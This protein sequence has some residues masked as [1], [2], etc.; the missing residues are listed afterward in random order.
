MIVFRRAKESDLEAI[1]QLAKQSGI[2]TLPDYRHFLA[3]R[4]ITSNDSFNN[5][6]STPGSEYYLF[7]LEDVSKNQVVGTSAIEACTGQAHPFYSFQIKQVHQTCEALK[8]R[9]D[10]ALLISSRMNEGKSE[11]CTLFLDPNFRH[12]GNGLLLSRARFLFMAEH[13]ERFTSSVI[14]ELRGFVDDTG[15]SPFWTHVG[16]HFFHIPFTKADKLTMT[17][18][19]QFID[20]LL[21]KSPI[22]I[23]LLPAEAQRVIGKPNHH[24]SPAMKI[25][26]SQGF[27]FNQSVDIFDAGPT[28]E[29]Q[30]TDIKTITTSQ[31]MTIEEFNDEPHFDVKKNALIAN[32][33]LDFRVTRGAVHINPEKQTAMISRKTAKIL[34]VELGDTLRVAPF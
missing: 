7:V 22:H 29:A 10:Y 25:L 21:P 2:T 1:C 27:Y 15:K 14:A 31:V 34:Q 18:D 20:D 28:L 24:S 23:N 17:T 5:D 16:S 19:K 6:V 33:Q 12:N 3:K 32:T 8:L 13:P 30:L 26:L 9:S 11:L 4:L